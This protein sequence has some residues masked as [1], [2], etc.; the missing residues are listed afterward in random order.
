MSLSTATSVLS[1]RRA[2]SRALRLGA[3]L[4]CAALSACGGFGFDG[5]QP[6]QP[7]QPV[8]VGWGGGP[9]PVPGLPPAPGPS[10]AAPAALDAGRSLL[11]TDHAVLQD[12]AAGF[13]LSRVLGQIAAQSQEAGL[14]A[15]GLFAR[16]WQTQLVGEG[17]CAKE[18]ALS[19]G[20][21]LNGFP[22]QCGRAEGQQAYN[23]AGYLAAY[24]PVALSNRFDLAPRDG[25]SCGEYRITFAKD[26][27]YGPG[28]NFLIFEAV[29]PNPAPGCGLA[30]CRPVAEFWAQ[31]SQIED[32]AERAARLS[33]FYFQG[34]PGFRP[35]VHA[36]HYGG[37]GAR[38]GQVRTNQFMEGPW[39]L[40]ELHLTATCGAGCALGVEAVPVGATPYPGLWDSSQ[41]GAYAARAQELQGAVVAQ[42]GALAAADLGSLGLALPAGSLAAESRVPDQDEALQAFTR[43]GRLG[44]SLYDRLRLALAGSGL[45]PEHVL[46][47][48]E[49]QTCAGCHQ[50]NNGGAAAQLGGGLVW[51]PSL[52]FVHV[53]EQASE[54]GPD[55]PR[56]AISP[57]LREVF[58]PQRQSILATYLASCA[59]CGG[60]GGYG[61]GVGQRQGAL[62][63]QALSPLLNP[64][65]S[66]H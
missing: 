26:P 53:S 16:L 37:R 40:R 8:V 19:G 42:A 5:G 6:G 59:G 17:G 47:R 55:G 11:V 22:L 18:S 51:R 9:V 61:Q 36:E 30:A 56:Y 54:R 48:A 39:T 65:G 45:T 14:D 62:Q 38:S 13:T 46:R 43:G 29:L 2:G 4:L 12:P 27:G 52:G 3:P 41:G 20:P 57:A 35:V 31:L 32:P 25:S 44:G 63:E 60:G 21:G 33:R 7:G 1:L 15:R 64:S 24:R 50:Y 34:L 66:A 58:L 49:T 23:A 10:C 28:R